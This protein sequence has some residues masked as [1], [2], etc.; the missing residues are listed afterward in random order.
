MEQNEIK[1]GLK[2]LKTIPLKW[3]ELFGHKKK[4]IFL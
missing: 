2:I 3:N 1:N 4:K